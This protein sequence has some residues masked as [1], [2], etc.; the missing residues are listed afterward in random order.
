[1]NLNPSLFSSEVDEGPPKVALDSGL[2]AIFQHL[3]HRMGSVS[4]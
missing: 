2:T 4:S 3:V 1:M